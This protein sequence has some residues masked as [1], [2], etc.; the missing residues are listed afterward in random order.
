[1]AGIGKL[2]P[3]IHMDC[4][5][6][7]LIRVTL[8]GEVTDEAFTQYIR[9]SNAVLAAEKRYVLLYEAIRDARVS[10]RSRGIQ[11]DWIKMNEDALRRL[12]IGA[13][14]CFESALTRGALT[15]VL[16][17]TKLPFEYTVLGNR[18]HATE[19]VHERLRNANMAIP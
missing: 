14:F 18:Q 5:R 8:S 9:D 10:P 17:M 2:T 12:C 15:A 16:W 6:Q 4:T 3:S 19:W 13:A 7:P 1:M 11:A